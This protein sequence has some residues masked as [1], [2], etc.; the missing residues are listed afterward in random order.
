MNVGTN[1]PP[2]PSSRRLWTNGRLRRSSRRYAEVLVKLG[3][4]SRVYG[5][6]RDVTADNFGKKL[7]EPAGCEFLGGRLD[8]FVCPPAVLAHEVAF[9]IVPT[10]DIDIMLF[11]ADE[12]EALTLANALTGPRQRED[13]FAHPDQRADLTTK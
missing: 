9:K 1:A 10:A 7:G 11:D 5:F 3:L 4:D 13:V 2:I 12:I 8:F 6:A